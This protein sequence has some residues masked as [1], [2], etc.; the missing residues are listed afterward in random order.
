MTKESQRRAVESQRQRM[1]DRGHER[2]EVIGPGRDK[3]LVRNIVK[4][5]AAGGP[6]AERLR[7][8]AKGATAP[9]KSTRGELLRAL[10][11]GPRFPDDFDISR[12]FTTGRDDNDL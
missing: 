3:E 12:E 11:S 6:E 8:Q 10:Q 1:R 9:K 2:Y 5:L 7:E 4:T